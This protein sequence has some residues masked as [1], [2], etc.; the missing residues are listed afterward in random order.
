[1]KGLT[2]KAKENP[3]RV[4]FAEADHY[5]ILKAA[6]QVKDE[7]IAKPILLGDKE[8]I[9]KMI[10]EY[11][12]DLEDVPII[13][14]RSHEENERREHFGEVFWEKR[15]RK[16][17][18]LFESR[19]IMR[20]RNYFGGMMIETNVADAMISGITRKY[21][22][23][24]RAAL[25]TIGVKPGVKRVCGMYILL[26]KKGP[27]FLADTTMNVDPTAEDLAE[28][29]ALTATCVKQ[30]NIV[31]R[32]AMLSYSNFGSVKGDVPE[33]VSKAVAM[34]HEQYPGMIVDGDIQANFALNNELLKE[35]FPFSELINKS[36]N[37]LIFPNLVSGNI[38]YKM[39]QEL[40]D[41]EAIGPILLGMK[42][43][44]HILQLGCS[45]RE[46]VNMVTIAVVDAQ[47]RGK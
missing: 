21:A 8:R 22:D 30:F 37:T 18:T 25:E 24:I 35:Q 39:M 44:A 27:I 10:T 1:M 36:V 9:H 16:G 13:D 5:K 17:Y 19:K 41:V 31:P 2:S 6:E 15:K 20:E 11:N 43:P 34:L 42:K 40:A 45:V 14:P 26:T 23:P 33:K 38:A 3:K 32:I 47:S 7:G 28:I 4:V 46:I 12:L 29:T